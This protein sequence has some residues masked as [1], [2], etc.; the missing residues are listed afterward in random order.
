LG[1]GIPHH[2]KQV[3]TH[4]TPGGLHKPKGCIGG[5]GRINGC[6]AH[7]QDINGYLCGQRVTGG[8][9]AMLRYHLR[10]GGKA[11]AGDSVLRLH[12]KHSDNKNVDK[13]YPFHNFN[14]LTF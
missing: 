13:S 5:Y 11:M 9:H 8:R 2:G 1:F 4:P 7:F 3:A 12:G 6:S 10:S 14:V